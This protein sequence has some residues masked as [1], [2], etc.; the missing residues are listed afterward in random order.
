MSPLID[1]SQVVETPKGFDAPQPEQFVAQHLLRGTLMHFMTV[2]LC[3]V[4][5]AA[6]D[7]DAVPLAE[8]WKESF[9]EFLQAVPGH[10]AN[11][12]TDQQSG[13]GER[14]LRMTIHDRETAV[15]G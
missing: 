13:E 15:E 8:R 9:V 11:V 1:A 6:D 5:A 2:G 10:Y 4:M 14:W 12:I 3:H 7:K